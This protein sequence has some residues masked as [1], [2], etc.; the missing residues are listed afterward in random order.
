MTAAALALRLLLQ[1]RSCR[2]C[3]EGT[4]PAAAAA[5]DAGRSGPGQ[6]RPLLTGLLPTALLLGRLVHPLLVTL[7]LLLLLLLL[8]LCCSSG[9]AS[10]ALRAARASSAFRGEGDALQNTSHAAATAAAV[11]VASPV[12]SIPSSARPSERLV[13]C[14]KV[15][16][17]PSCCCCCS[18]G[19]CCDPCCLEVP[20]RDGDVT[21]FCKHRCCCCCRW[22]DSCDRDRCT[23]RAGA[24][25][26]PAG[27]APTCCLTG[28]CCRCCC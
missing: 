23:A 20:N 14:S 10:T 11:A 12:A 8:V 9:A 25:A 18:C 27:T 19:C 21:D 16:P 26:C 28:L 6:Q 5:G 4:T 3:C 7:L 22:G 2:W 13:S 15:Q 1:G 24:F 17:G